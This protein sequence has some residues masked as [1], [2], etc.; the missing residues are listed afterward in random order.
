MSFSWIEFGH[1]LGC[2]PARRGSFLP[3]N[4]S[5]LWVSN[6]VP[7]STSHAKGALV[8]SNMG[9]QLEA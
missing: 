7:L 4:F 8:F 5:R 6:Q 3:C 9:K 2:L 1:N